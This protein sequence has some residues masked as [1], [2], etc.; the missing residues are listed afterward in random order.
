MGSNLGD[1][2]YGKGFAKITG[3]LSD[4]ESFTT[5]RTNLKKNN[6]YSFMANITSF[7]KLLIGH[8]KNIY[9]GSWLEIDGTRVIVHNMLATDQ[10]VEY[11]HELSITG[12]IYLQIIVIT[13]SAD[14]V[15]YS[16]DQTY[17]ITDANWNGDA[18]GDTFVESVGSSL[19]DCVFTWS[20]EDFRK[21]IW[22]FGDSYFGIKDAA[23]WCKYSADAGYADNVLLNAYPGEAT[24]TAIQALNNAIQYYGKPDV[25]VWCLGMND[26]SDTDD[27]TPSSG[28]ITGINALNTIC[29]AYNIT[30][31]YATIPTVPNINHEGKNKF[32]RNSGNRYIDFAAAVGANGDGTWK[33]GMLS[34]DNIHPT[35]TGAKALYHRAIAD[36]PEITFSNFS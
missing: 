19:T 31:I 2:L 32:I 29:E 1:K 10:T 11:E 20:S 34:G 36:C 21:P 3:N 25:I 12:Y 13:G 27:D 6:V 16:G 14:I 7:N 24:V 4:G 33:T 26:G 18:N 30:P 5:P 35:A 17:T 23:R 15:L 8:G 28:W 9:S 22:M